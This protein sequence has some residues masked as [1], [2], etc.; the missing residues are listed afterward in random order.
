MAL[1]CDFA[2]E[3]LAR[4]FEFAVTR[5]GIGVLVARVA[6]ATT[7]GRC[8]WCGYLLELGCIGHLHSLTFHDQV[9]VVGLA[10][11]MTQWGS[12]A[13]FFAVRVVGLALR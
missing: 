8:A 5:P 1:V 9:E 7:P 6:A 12:R 2:G 10:T 4:P 13:R 3:L 11:V